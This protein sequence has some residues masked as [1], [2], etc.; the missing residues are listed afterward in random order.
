MWFGLE[1]DVVDL[2]PLV[3]ASL[4]PKTPVHGTTLSK[5]VLD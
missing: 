2:P 1:I 5:P 3:E 4:K